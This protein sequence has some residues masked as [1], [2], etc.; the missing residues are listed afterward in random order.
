MYIQYYIR[1][2]SLSQKGIDYSKEDQR[3]S[4]RGSIPKESSSKGSNPKE[5]RPFSI[6]VKVGEIVTLM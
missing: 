3:N 1:L 2:I 6:D 5:R 4:D